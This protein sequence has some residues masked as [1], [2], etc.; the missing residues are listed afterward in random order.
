MNIINPTLSANEIAILPRSYNSLVNLQVKLKYEDSDRELTPL[1]SNDAIVGNNLVFNIDGVYLEGQRYTLT[2]NQDG[3]NI[4]R[5]KILV[6]EFGQDNY[7]I[8]N[9]EFVIDT[10][11]DSDSIPVYE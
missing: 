10:D 6:T 1:V 11:T 7:T 4:F 5:G 2:V 3:K 9:N 8:N